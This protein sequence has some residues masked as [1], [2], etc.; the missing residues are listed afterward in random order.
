M[1]QNFLVVMENFSD[2]TFLMS[3]KFIIVWLHVI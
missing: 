3:I 1:N 2:A